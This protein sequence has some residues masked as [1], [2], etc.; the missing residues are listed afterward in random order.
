MAGN[1]EGLLGSFFSPDDYKKLCSFFENIWMSNAPYK[2]FMARRAFNLNFLFINAKKAQYNE[3]YNVDNIIS[4]T[5][6][7]LCAEEIADYYEMIGRFPQILIVDD[8]Q[9]HGRGVTKLITSLEL[10][11]IEF[12]QKARNQRESKE[13]IHRELFAAVRI[14][15]FAQNTRGI[16]LDKGL[17]VKAVTFLPSDRL[18]VLSQQISRTLQ[19]C[20]VANTSYVLSAELPWSFC[21]KEY[22]DGCIFDKGSLF[23]YRGNILRYYYHETNSG[24][25]ETIRVYNSDK[26]SRLKR[27]ATSLVIFG[28]IP[29]GGEEQFGALCRYMAGRI[30][31]IVP[32][33]RIA[34]IFIYEQEELIRPRAQMLSYILS[35]LNYSYFY[36]EKITTDSHSIYKALIQSDYTKIAA[37]FDK[38]QR[39]QYELLQIFSYISRNDVLKADVYEEL[40]NYV[41][42]AGG[43]GQ[44]QSEG[45]KDD[46]Y[47]VGQWNQEE[48]GQTCTDVE[49]IHEIAEDIFYDVGMDAEYDAN[50]CSRMQKKFDPSMPGNDAVRFVQYLYFMKKNGVQKA[51]SVGSLFNL[52]DSGLLSMNIEADRKRGVVQCVLK[53]GELSTFVLPRRFSTFVPALSIVERG[54]LKRGSNKK[55]V[56]GQFIDYLQAHCYRQDGK[57]DPKDVEQLKKLERSKSSLLYM[58]NAGQSIQDWDIDLLTEEDRFSHGMDEN[59]NYNAG[60]YSSWESDEADRVSYYNYCARE[61]LRFGDM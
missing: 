56:V 29:Y 39:L 1:S 40:T 51:V 33:S 3:R 35:V 14:Y 4:N 55:M 53:A 5:A 22:A 50:E 10:L 38:P 20:G 19:Q 58:Y 41:N 6:L 60:R 2:V 15:V 45:D 59:G 61:F 42:Y 46:Y 54:Y 34:D 47:Q 52:M 43:A 12:L 17:A 25:L 23:Q 48:T 36:R 16:L 11:V 26:N 7:L 32:Y 13:M 8:I 37:N 24:I 44:K 31:E 18:R 27:M 49:A 21:R 30:R 57:V 28:D 9:V